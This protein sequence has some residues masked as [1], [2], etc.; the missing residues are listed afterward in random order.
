MFFFFLLYAE[1]VLKWELLNRNRNFYLIS[2]ALLIGDQPSPSQ[3]EEVDY[4]TEHTQRQKKLAFTDPVHNVSLKDTVQ[5]QVSESLMS[6]RQ[7]IYRTS[8]T[9]GFLV[10]QLIAMR[11]MIGDDRF[12][13][14]MLSLSPDIEEQLKDFISL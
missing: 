7:T 10:C 13:A 9:K 5:H 11:R 1:S 3:Y 12:D 8:N 4:E 6:F 2:S 14:L